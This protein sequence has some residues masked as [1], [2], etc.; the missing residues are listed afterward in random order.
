MVSG[1]ALLR[2]RRGAGPGSPD[3]T[4]LAAL[5]LLLLSAASAVAQPVAVLNDWKES[6]PTSVVSSG[7]V[8]NLVY[9]NGHGFAPGGKVN[10]EFWGATG[11]WAPLN[12][13]IVTYTLLAIT[14]T[15]TSV[16]LDRADFCGASGKIRFTSTASIETAS[17][18]SV[19]NNILTL[20][21]RGVGGTTA[22]NQ[23]TGEVVYCSYQQPHQY[24]TARI[25]DD[26]T[27]QIPLDSSSFGTFT[28]TANVIRF[29][30]PGTQA[31]DYPNL[32]ESAVAYDSQGDA[33]YTQSILS[34]TTGLA[35]IHQCARAYF[36]P[37]GFAGKYPPSV[38][39]ITSYVVNGDG[40]ATL[41]LGGAAACSNYS[42]G[43]NRIVYTSGLDLYVLNIRPLY[44]TAASGIQVTVAGVDSSVAAGTYSGP[45][46]V[47]QIPSNAPVPYMWHYS[48]FPFIRGQGG[49]MGDYVKSGNFDPASNR[50][51]FTVT[52]DSLATYNKTNL[53][54][55]FQVGT[56]TKSGSWVYSA[57]NNASAGQHFYHLMPPVNFYPDSPV[58]VE[59]NA[60]P[61]HQVG[62][63]SYSKWGNDPV[64]N[65]AGV[66]P[67]WPGYDSVTHFHYFDSLTNWYIDGNFGSNTT[68]L[69]MT[70]G[71]EDLYTVPNEP[72]ELVSTRAITWTNAR[73]SDGQPGYEVGWDGPKLTLVRYQVNYSISG[74]LKSLGFS[75]GANGGTVNGLAS[76]YVGVRWL[77]PPMPRAANLWVGIRPTVGIDSTT[78]G[79]QAPVWIVTQDDLN[80]QV[81]DHVTVSNVSGNAAA[82]QANV[83]ISAVQPR[84]LFQRWNQMT[85]NITSVVPGNGFTTLT[86]DHPHGFTTGTV[87]NIGYTTSLKALLG[88]WTITVTGNSTFTIPTTVAGS[89]YTNDASVKQAGTLVN[90]V[91]AGGGGS[92]ESCT[93][94]F[95]VNHNILPGWMIWVAGAT[96]T[97]LSPV[98]AYS[99]YKVTSVPSPN[100]LTFNCPN[101]PDGTY[102][103][104]YGAAYPLGIVT[105]PGVAL[106]P[107]TAGNGAYSNKCTSLGNCGQIVS[108]ED[109]R[110][111][112][113]IS[114]SAGAVHRNPGRTGR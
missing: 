64:Y 70:I 100:S 73:L 50:L 30:N 36:G 80:M 79:G 101:V 55:P 37:S 19:A 97:N 114:L 107:G 95:T 93:A 76:S 86:T 78:A 32:A 74:S 46:P 72:E 56:Y 96:S 21:A 27:L 28:G 31:Y 8:T 75:S 3:S 48:G 22:Q 33:S 7:S 84:Q 104:D 13:Q 113:E 60:S 89:G 105:F 52:Y 110:N 98:G 2:L 91:A 34:C 9:A 68:P 4:P 47:L 88:V 49:Y 10:I 43:S 65:G 54:G 14:S 111:F 71:Q 23:W 38:C 57:G 85:Y 24:W 59:V 62:A 66:Y 15:D 82:N 17:Y 83:P 109:N 81:G 77:S 26:D 1:R 90:I 61:Q 35:D 42:Y 40:T 41:T 51:H 29:T 53:E 106:D 20:S 39:P 58:K 112:A 5:A 92:G 25:I 67:G 11:T 18:S 45:N 99:T 103:S 102:D 16:D 69:N 44:V 87:V 63:N 6:L 12:T 94:T 108:T